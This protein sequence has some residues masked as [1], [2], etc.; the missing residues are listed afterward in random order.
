V[1]ITGGGDAM[2][3]KIRAKLRRCTINAGKI[4]VGVA[5]NGD[6]GCKERWDRKYRALRMTHMVPLYRTKSAWFR[7]YVE[8]QLID[9]I[10]DVELRNRVRGGGGRVG[11]PVY[12]VYVAYN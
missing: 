5:S 8:T 1:P 6:K 10:L 11:K 7:R 4:W 12:T 2:L 9:L 3:N